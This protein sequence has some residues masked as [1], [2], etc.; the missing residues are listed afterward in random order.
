MSCRHKSREGL[1]GLKDL[2][3]VH[4]LQEFSETKE[5]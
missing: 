2:L 1:C 3:R 4:Y 5:V